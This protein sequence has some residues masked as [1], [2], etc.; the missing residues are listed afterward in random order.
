[1]RPRTKH[2]A[3]KYHH[4]RSPFSI[5]YWQRHYHQIDINRRPGSRYLHK[6]TNR[7]QISIIEETPHGMV[8]SMKFSLRIIEQTH[9]TATFTLN[10]RGSVGIQT[11]EYVSDPRLTWSS[12]Y[13]E[14]CD[15]ISSRQSLTFWKL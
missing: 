9:L 6:I 14:L 8:K 4:F 15:T 10:K 13:Q 5:T 2:I 1:M 3:Q 7:S 11:S 12:Q